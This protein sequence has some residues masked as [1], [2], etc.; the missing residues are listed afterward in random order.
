MRL[1]TE[2]CKSE[3]WRALRDSEQDFNDDMGN[4]LGT[5]T[6]LLKG[7]CRVRVLLSGINSWQVAAN[8]RWKIVHRVHSVYALGQGRRRFKTQ[9]LSLLQK[10]HF[11]FAK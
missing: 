11:F 8:K 5:V 3:E 4:A 2:E 10:D 7:K 9:L 1:V 6:R